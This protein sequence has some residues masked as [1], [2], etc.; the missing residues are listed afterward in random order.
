MTTRTRLFL[1]SALAVTVVATGLS[2]T[3]SAARRL[4]NPTIVA[5]LDIGRVREGLSERVDAQAGLMAQSQ[6]IEVENNERIRKI[7]ELQSEMADVVDSA[8][9]EALQ[10]ELDLHLVRVAAWRNYIQQ[11]IDIEKSLLLQ[12][13]Y[14]K[15]TQAVQE[16]AEIEGIDIVLINDAGQQVQTIADS[17]VARE[18]QVRQQ[19]SSRRIIYASPGVDITEQLIVRMNNAYAAA[20]GAR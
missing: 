20:Q 13:L 8:R 16:L 4:A 17:Q 19:I 7:E 9:R 18:L 1:L 12:D 3:A 5:T 2:V 6:S 10:E 14:R 11:Q 15:I